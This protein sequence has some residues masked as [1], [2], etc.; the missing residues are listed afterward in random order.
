MWGLTFKAR[1]DDLRH[2]PSLEVARRLRAKGA[3]VQ[4]DDPTVERP[5]DGVDVRND[6]YSACEGAK[7]LAVG[8]E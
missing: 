3:T 5:I 7:V 1:T 8:T 6:P 4:A 2:S